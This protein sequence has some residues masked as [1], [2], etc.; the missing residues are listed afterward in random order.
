MSHRAALSRHRRRGAVEPRGGAPRRRVVARLRSGPRAVAAAGLAETAAV[1]APRGLAHNL[2]YLIYSI[3]HHDGFCHLLA[4]V[5][6]IRPPII[7][8]TL[9][10]RPAACSGAHRLS[11][12]RYHGDA[13]AHEA[14]DAG[15]IG[16]AVAAEITGRAGHLEPG[17]GHGLPD[18][19]V[20]GR[21]RCRPSAGRPACRRRAAGQAPAPASL[22]AGHHR[23]VAA[24]PGA[25]IQPPCACSLTSLGSVCC[26][27]CVLP[28]LSPQPAHDV[29]VLLGRR[30][31]ACRW[32]RTRAERQGDGPGRRYLRPHH[33]RG[34]RLDNAAQGHA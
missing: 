34:G 15:W 16:A 20:R 32:L 18:A 2:V 9:R 17:Q 5:V 30:A 14:A 25:A 7:D 6:K 27:A 33:A 10:R 19:R 29:P 13:Y 22:S 4:I 23:A 1:S 28:L 26:A 8:Q 31:A 11:T 3:N 21:C 12:L 24:P